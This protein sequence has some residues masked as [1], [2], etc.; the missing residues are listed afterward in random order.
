MTLEDIIEEILQEE[1]EDD[2]DIDDFKQKR[3][4]I[5]EKI[6]MLFQDNSAGAQLSKEEFK[7]VTEYLAAHVR[8]FRSKRLTRDC[9]KDLLAES[10]V[11]TI[12]SDNKPFNHT[13]DVLDH[14][15]EDKITSIAQRQYNNM[16]KTKGLTVD[17][18]MGS[19]IMTSQQYNKNK[20]GAEE[21]GDVVLEIR[22]PA[23]VGKVREL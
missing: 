4:Q 23:K 11:I 14:G 1:I 18:G 13:L 21:N 3:Q 12:E 22:S 7:A 20:K 8:P 6:M 9:L 2:K 5:K 15:P 16:V 10:Q 17:T 19:G